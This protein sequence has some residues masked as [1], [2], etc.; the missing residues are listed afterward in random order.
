MKGPWRKLSLSLLDSST[1]RDPSLR[2]LAVDLLL[3]CDRRGFIR[4][5]YPEMADRLGRSVDELLELLRLLEEPQAQSRDQTAGGAFLIRLSQNPNCWRIV[6]FLKYQ[7]ETNVEKYKKYKVRKAK[8]MRAYRARLKE[9]S[10]TGALPRDRKVTGALPGVTDS[11]RALPEAL[12]ALHRES[13]TG[14]TGVLPG[15]TGALPRNKKE[16]EKE[17]TLGGIGVPL[18]TKKDIDEWCSRE[19]LQGNQSPNGKEVIITSEWIA[20]VG[21]NSAYR[22]L[23]VQVEFGKMCAFWKEKNRPLPPSRLDF[24][25][26]LNRDWRMN[27]VKC[28]GEDEPLESEEV[29]RA[30]GKALGQ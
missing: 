11:D 14:V 2:G 3:L 22:T 8:N 30:I 21:E 19:L 5:D 10:V 16:K 15:V 18:S 9:K 24:I 12:P 13:V 4:M 29:M 20:K 25:C 23:D 7:A 1:L 27:Q 6:N 26:W 17:S 28:P